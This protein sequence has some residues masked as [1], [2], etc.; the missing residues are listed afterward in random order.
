M[1]E[2][3][4]AYL[5]TVREQ[6]RWKRAR[7]VLVRELEQHLEDQ[8][9]DFIKEGNSPEDAERLAVRDMGDP[10]T[11]GT[12]LDAVHRP[13]PQWGLLVLTIALALT[14][15]VLRAV[16]FDSSLRPTSINRSIE[17]MKALASF[18]VG[19]A[20]ML[21]M[22]FLDISRPIRHAK[23]VYIGTLLLGAETFWHAVSRV[24]F[25]SLSSYQRSFYLSLCLPVVYALWI[26]A[27]RG[28]RW[29]GLFLIIA[30]GVPLAVIC[31]V[32][33]SM[34]NLFTLLFSGFTLALIASWLDWFGV[35]R[36]KGICVVLLAAFGVL[37]YL[38]WAGYISSLLGI[39]QIALHPELDPYGRGYT[40]FILQIYLKDIPFL[41]L[42]NPHS[43]VGLAAGAR[44]YVDQYS[45]PIDISK[46]F[47]PVRIAV[48]WGWL[49]LLLLLAA[50][51]A[52]LAWLLVKGLRQTYLPGRFV[53]LAV[54]VMLGFQTLGS[55]ALNLGLFPLHASL[56]LVVGNL[57]TVVDMALIGLALSVFRGES[58]GR[59]EPAEP[60]RPRKRL[61]IQV[62]YQ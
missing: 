41:R 34:A 24:P 30:G 16:F 8:R 4:Q 45:T 31:M 5:E 10:V 38:Y 42:P 21:G 47:L 20:A 9:D 52:L 57:Q 12:E 44:L 23:A 32:C 40:N 25:I 53:V 22:Y 27:W 15:A 11:V 49:P 37:A 17:A 60:L 56:P 46:D 54:T 13:K 61:R 1:P 19:T 14:G 3:I 36:R 43:A 59:E 50:L 62:K 28:K 39:L 26:Q 2:T 48:E 58:I 18:G 33:S 6:I 29:K 7:P 35:G 55:L 51:T